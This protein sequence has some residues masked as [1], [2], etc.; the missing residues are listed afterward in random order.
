A[1][2]ELFPRYQ[3]PPWSRTFYTE[4]HNDY[5][6]VL[7]EVG[8][9]GFGLLFWFFWQEGSRLYRGL[10]TVSP[11][12]LPVLAALVAALGTMVF[13]ELFD[14]NLQLPANAF[15]FTLLF[16]LALRL[17]GINVQPSTVDGQRRF[18]VLVVSGVGVVALTLCLLALRQE[19]PP[20]PYNIEDPD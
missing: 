12:A 17:T 2:P 16:A 8:L 1:W 19:G 15:L 9:L 18:Q 10:K 7:A 14:F 13:H 4:A 20:Y 3:R 11:G 6:Q 5:V